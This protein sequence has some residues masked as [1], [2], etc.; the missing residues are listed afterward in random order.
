[1]TSLMSTAR[2]FMRD[3][4]SMPDTVAKLSKEILPNGGSSIG[5]RVRALQ[6]QMTIVDQRSLVIIDASDHPMFRATAEG[7]FT[8]V[9]RAFYDLT[10]ALRDDVMGEGWV[11]VIWPEDRAR[12]V[13]AWEDAVQ[14]ERDFIERF[15]VSSRLGGPAPVHCRA[16]VMRN[17]DGTTVGF[18]GIMSL[19]DRNAQ[20][21]QTRT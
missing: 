21:Q 4:A 3:F 13:E 6:D 11:N 1:M 14:S 19:E 17:P 9:N 10:G 12:V 20:A 8:F 7:G 18:Y 16:R 15:R 5:D 2:Q